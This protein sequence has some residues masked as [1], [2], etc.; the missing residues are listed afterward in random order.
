MLLILPLTRLWYGNH[1]LYIF[2]SVRIP[3]PIFHWALALPK[4]AWLLHLQRGSLFFSSYFQDFWI[5]NSFELKTKASAF[6]CV[7]NSLSLHNSRGVIFLF[8]SRLMMT[9]K[10]TYSSPY[11]VL[12]QLLVKTFLLWS[13]N[14]SKKWCT[15]NPMSPEKYGGHNLFLG[16]CVYIDFFHIWPKILVH[17]YMLLAHATPCS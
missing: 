6:L 8:V 16:T 3:N 11:F 5:S 7:R 15:R 9:E 1:S 10:H 12:L 14:D 17:Y 4:F 2:L 13:Q